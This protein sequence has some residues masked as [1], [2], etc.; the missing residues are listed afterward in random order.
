MKRKKSSGERMSA[1]HCLYQLDQEPD[2]STYNLDM[3]SAYCKVSVMLKALDL[4]SL[5]TSILYLTKIIH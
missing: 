5:R 4:S 1:K 3:H 2:Q